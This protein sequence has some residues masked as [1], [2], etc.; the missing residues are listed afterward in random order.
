MD[1]KQVG[2]KIAELR[3][4]NN[5]TQ[6]ELAEKLNVIDKTIS[7]WEC[8]Y[9]L[10]DIVIVPEIAAIFNVRIEE[11]LGEEPVA[12]NTEELHTEAP[13]SV[14]VADKKYS[15]KKIMIAAFAVICILIG[16]CAVLLTVFL[17]KPIDAL[18]TID[19]D[20]FKVAKNS[21]GDC[22]FITAF[23]YEECMSLELWGTDTGRFACQESWTESN[24]ASV[25]N[26]KITGKYSIDNDKIFFYG[27]KLIDPMETGKLRL[28]GQLGLD[29]FTADLEYAEDGTIA[30]VVFLADT[31][32]AVTSA[33][34]R[35]TKYANYF[36]REESE[37]Y[38]EPVKHGEITFEQCL[39]LPEFAT[40][41]LGITLPYRISCELE[42][43][44]FYVG[45]IIEEK[46]VKVNL[47]YSDGTTE[48]L[49]NFE[50][51]LIGRELTVS[52]SAFN[53]HKTIETGKMTASVKIRVRYG[54]S[55]E[56]AESSS[57]D[58]A[59]FT[60]YNTNDWI[61]FGCLELFGSAESGKFIYSEN[62]GKDKFS[63]AAVV[64]GQYSVTEDVIH[65]VSTAVYTDGNY[66]S[67]FYINSEGDWFIAYVENDFDAISFKTG[68]LARHLFGHFCSAPNETSFSR[69]DGE[70]YFE[71]LY[72][73]LSDRAKSCIATY[74][75]M[76][77]L[78]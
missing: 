47:I 35:W 10:P 51:E 58:F 40:V 54:Y 77:N 14:A 57:A 24:G 68:Y 6:R 48:R 23:G 8:G 69:E 19:C 36:S 63:S 76:K 62:C 56:R 43:Y 2:K 27:E 32:N 26:C 25:L 75:Y 20:C 33:F 44:E 22:V 53:V 18:E 66:Q 78:C 45:E 4:K 60:V 55:W 31:K 73:G 71:R 37:I 70:V 11:I 34:G 28:N 38:F 72:D 41:S 59:Y 9:G 12:V 64:V 39:R 5:M 30:A 52:D 29:C 65:F 42:R 15:K 13:A 50:C 61:S 17:K 7:R 74:A 3:K 16:V 67:K 46:D 49:D 1:A 21:D